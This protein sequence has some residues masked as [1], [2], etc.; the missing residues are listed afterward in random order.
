MSFQ[1][2]IKIV[3]PDERPATNHQGALPT[4]EAHRGKFQ[5]KKIRKLR[6]CD[7]CRVLEAELRRFNQKLENFETSI[8]NQNSES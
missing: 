5:E 1:A 6:K 3:L 8:A 2:I 4:I 7:K